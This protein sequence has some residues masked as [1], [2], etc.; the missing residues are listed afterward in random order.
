MKL[1]R[2]ESAYRIVLIQYG[3]WLIQQGVMLPPG[4]NDARSTDDLA[5]EFFALSEDGV[6]ADTLKTYDRWCKTH[7]STV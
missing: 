2:S 1:T 3:E 7:L 5:D 6:H 4:F